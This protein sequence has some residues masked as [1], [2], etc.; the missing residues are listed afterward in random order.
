MFDMRDSIWDP[1]NLITK[2]IS[3]SVLIKLCRNW[4]PAPCAGMT[5]FAMQIAFR[6]INVRIVVCGIR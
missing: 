5:S 2:N 1:G 3:Y 6:K 4:I